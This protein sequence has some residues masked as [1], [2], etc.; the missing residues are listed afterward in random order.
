MPHS[1][2]R[3]RIIVSYALLWLLLSLGAALTYGQG[4][5]GGVL[6]LV[7]LF[8]V[9]LVF[10]LLPSSIFSVARLQV[11]LL[12]QLALLLTAMLLLPEWGD[13]AAAPIAALVQLPTTLLIFRGARWLE[14]SEAA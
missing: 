10:A 5:Q 11:L 6:V 3:P 9:I 14:A 8:P 2:N 1:L 7:G 13:L 4:W 12:V